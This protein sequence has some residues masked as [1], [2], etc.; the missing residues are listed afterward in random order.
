MTLKDE[1]NLPFKAGFTREAAL[2][3]LCNPEDIKIF[4]SYDSTKSIYYGY[5]KRKKKNIKFKKFCKDI[6]LA[7][8][9][10][11]IENYQLGDFI[12]H[13]HF[14]EIDVC[15]KDTIKELTGAKLEESPHVL[16]SCAPFTTNPKSLGVEKY[17]SFLF[18]APILKDN[19]WMDNSLIYMKNENELGVKRLRNGNNFSCDFLSCKD[20]TL[21]SELLKEI[22]SG[23][24]SLGD[25]FPI[26]SLVRPSEVNSIIHFF[27]KNWEHIKLRSIPE[28]LD[29]EVLI[30]KLFEKRL[31]GDSFSSL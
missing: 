7:C 13:N 27:H 14:P 22:N 2:L 10:N 18:I 23:Y 24:K 30:Q 8:N 9:K 26:I 29:N 6:I 31:Y 21:K 12:K 4:E 11:N 25:Y 17:H 19:Y 1:K 16:I 28:L 5:K 3:F 20:N 15:V